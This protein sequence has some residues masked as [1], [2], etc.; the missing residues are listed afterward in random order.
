M[1]IDLKREK[2]SAIEEASSFWRGLWEAEGTGNSQADWL[3]EVRHVIFEKVP[4]PSE[5]AWI[6]VTDEAMNVLKR[7][8]KWSS[9]GPD[10][11][12]NFL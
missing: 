10:K 6:L 4:P 11:L 8:T 3:N 7:K 5:E 12:V 2:F 1:L 9:P